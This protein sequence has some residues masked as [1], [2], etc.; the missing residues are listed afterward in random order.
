MSDKTPLQEI[1]ADIEG[2][3]ET[4][5][6]DSDCDCPPEWQRCVCCRV[7]NDLRRTVKKIYKEQERVG[8][9]GSEIKQ[10]RVLLKEAHTELSTL[11]AL[12]LHPNV[13]SETDG[14]ILLLRRIDAAIKKG[15]E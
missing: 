4:L 13:D 12:T 15:E 11:D 10:L 1:E 7:R 8:G 2:A 5:I 14:L 9:L 6:E 3:I